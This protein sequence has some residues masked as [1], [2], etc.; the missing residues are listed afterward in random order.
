MIKILFWALVVLTMPTTWFY[1]QKIG[2]QIA[3]I[4]GNAQAFWAGPI[5]ITII[6]WSLLI[7][8][9]WYFKESVSSRIWLP[10]L[11]LFIST[12]IPTLITYIA[13]MMMDK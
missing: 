12:N 4:I 13:L 11:I 8:M 9:E 3:Q 10:F 6:A 2:N 5:L 7:L 1:Y